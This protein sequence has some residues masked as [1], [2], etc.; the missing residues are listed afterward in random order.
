MGLLCAW[1]GPILKYTIVIRIMAGQ[2]SLTMVTAFVT[3]ENLS[4]TVKFLNYFAT[5]SKTRCYTL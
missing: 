4:W 2:W 3:A 1:E 5:S